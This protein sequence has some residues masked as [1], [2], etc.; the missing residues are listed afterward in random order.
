[1]YVATFT[2]ATHP[3]ILRFWDGT[4]WLYDEISYDMNISYGY[5]LSPH[6]CHISY[7]TW[8]IITL[9]LAPIPLF[10]ILSFLHLLL[11]PSAIPSLRAR[12][13]PEKEKEALNYLFLLVPL[14]NITLPLIWKSFA[15]VYTADVTVF[16]SMYAWKVCESHLIDSY[17]LR[18][19]V[20]L[21][22]L[23]FLTSHRYLSMS[24]PLWLIDSHAPIGIGGF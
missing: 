17:I 21:R 18:E 1:M 24:K 7:V 5:Q 20:F 22:F 8:R 9:H 3:Q 11:F 2:I 23:G 13:C 14:I 12:D 10:S 15:A 19:I 4:Y 16:L 6:T